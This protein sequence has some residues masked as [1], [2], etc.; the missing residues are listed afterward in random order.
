MDKYEIRRQ[1]LL[2][3]LRDKFAGKRS[4]L[5]RALDCEPS[6]VSRMLYEDGKYGKRRIGDEMAEA[7]AKTF[8]I[9]MMGYQAGIEPESATLVSAQLTY[10]DRINQDEMEMISD[11][12]LRG[13]IDRQVIR[14]YIS[15]IPMDVDLP[16]RLRNEK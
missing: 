11:Y 14:Q 9:D 4:A 7:I 3:I 13:A 8:G 12:R 16:D 2:E 15:D 6:Y 5:A 10:I 1:K